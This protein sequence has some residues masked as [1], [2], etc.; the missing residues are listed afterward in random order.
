MA[1]KDP[2]TRS[3][4]ATL[5][6]YEQHARHGDETTRAGTAA[7]L[8]TFEVKVDPTCSLP[9]AERQRRA[10]AARRAYFQRLALASVQARRKRSARRE[11]RAKAGI[12]KVATLGEETTLVTEGR[13]SALASD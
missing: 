8:A 5:G 11:I 1:A 4:I 12:E 9:P 2:Y 6:A 10:T 13:S 3:A 7:F